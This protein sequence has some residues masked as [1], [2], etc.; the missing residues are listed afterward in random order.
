MNEC[1]GLS[2]RSRRVKRTFGKGNATSVLSAVQ[3]INCYLEEIV[4]CDGKTWDGSCTDRFTSL[5]LQKV[6]TVVSVHSGVFISELL[7]DTNIAQ[8]IF[9]L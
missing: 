4:P 2:F 6:V 3:A 8:I 7:P 5:A 9:L 1:L